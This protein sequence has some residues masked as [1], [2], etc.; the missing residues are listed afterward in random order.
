MHSENVKICNNNMGNKFQNIYL[1]IKNT[2]LI[3]NN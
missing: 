2:K 1:W 3:K